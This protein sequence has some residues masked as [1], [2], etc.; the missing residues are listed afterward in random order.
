MLGIDSIYFNGIWIEYIPTIIL[1]DIE[2]T[3]KRPIGDENLY[4][5]SPLLVMYGFTE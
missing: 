5:Q 2:N 3:L 1:R 4:R